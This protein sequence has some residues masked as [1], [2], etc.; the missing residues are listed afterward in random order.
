[1]NTFKL[2]G[3]ASHLAQ[4]FTA[5]NRLNIAERLLSDEYEK[6]EAIAI[7]AAMAVTMPT[8]ELDFLSDILNSLQEKAE[9][10]EK[11]LDTSPQR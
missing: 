6:E 5:G 8:E 1:M 10:L 3:E 2:L 4:L 7:I 9:D 11:P